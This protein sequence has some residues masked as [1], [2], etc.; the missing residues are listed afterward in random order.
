MENKRENEF[1]GNGEPGLPFLAPDAFSRLDETDDHLFY[2]RDRFVNHLDSL[3]LDTVKRLIGE[4]VHEENPVILD[5]MAGWD[6][7]LPGNLEPSKVV[8]LGLNERE[9]A[10]NQ[11]LDEFVVKDVNRDPQL[12]F[13][14]N[15]FDV[16]L[17]I[18][19][20]DYLVHPIEVFKEVGRVLR[21]I[22]RSGHQAMTRLW[23]FSRNPT[24][25]R[26]RS[27]GSQPQTV[28]SAP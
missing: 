7:H 5:L 13:E 12:P 27:P 19:S 18:V 17:N 22:P 6:S 1:S 14:D 4:L 20:V 21:P 9:L 11:V 15:A 23:R 10:G 28:R 24:Q 8:G 2:D 3:A 16:V 26:A 25:T